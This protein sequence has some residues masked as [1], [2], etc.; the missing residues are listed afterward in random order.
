MICS[1]I[2]AAVGFGCTSGSG[3][4]SCFVGMTV[5]AGLGC[6]EEA[7][8]V[9]QSGSCRIALELLSFLYSG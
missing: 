1:G 3:T 4:D 8:L 7:R 6:N 2:G 5:M 9:F